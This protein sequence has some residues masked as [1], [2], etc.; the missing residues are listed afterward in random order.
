MAVALGWCRLCCCCVSVCL[1]LFYVVGFTFVS[2]CC[3][4]VAAALWLHLNF[5]SAA[6]IV[7]A[8]THLSERQKKEKERMWWNETKRNEMENKLN[9]RNV[10]TREVWHQHFS[11]EQTAAL[12]LFLLVFSSH[13]LSFYFERRLKAWLHII[14]NAREF[15]H[16][17]CIALGCAWA[18]RKKRRNKLQLNLNLFNSH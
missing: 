6:F 11:C 9:T 13:F 12:P 5:H 14:W 3:Y 17:R 10:F 2:A 1:L 8:S 4:S 15:L 18:S 16:I 7:S